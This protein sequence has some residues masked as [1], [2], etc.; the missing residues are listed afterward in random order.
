MLYYT[1]KARKTAL[2]RIGELVVKLANTKPTDTLTLQDI[3]EL[4]HYLSRLH[5][6]LEREIK[7]NS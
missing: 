2:K 1:N 3:S 7:E 4:N 6:E 5:G